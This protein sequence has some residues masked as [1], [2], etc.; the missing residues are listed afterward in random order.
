MPHRTAQQPAGATI[1]PRAGL[2]H[3]SEALPG[4]E[5]FILYRQNGTRLGT[6]CA[7]EGQTDIQL[8]EAFLDF[9]DRKAPHLKLVPA[10]SLPRPE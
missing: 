4:T 9:L 8:I 2:Y 10:Y 5:V 6:W 3:D 7:G 1:R